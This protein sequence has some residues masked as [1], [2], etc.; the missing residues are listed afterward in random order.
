MEGADKGGPLCSA[1]FVPE[2]T[3]CSPAPD[4][5]ITSIQIGVNAMSGIVWQGKTLILAA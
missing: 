1:P 4:W 2:T 5:V 3:I